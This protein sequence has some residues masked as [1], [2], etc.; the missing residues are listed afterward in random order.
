MERVN[1]N[2][3]IP[4]SMYYIELDNDS[5]KYAYKAKHYGKFIEYTYNNMY[6]Y[7]ENIEEIKSKNSFFEEKG[8]KLV[9]GVYWKFFKMKKY[10]IERRIINSLIQ[11]ITGDENFIYLKD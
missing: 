4:N 2:E 5:L 10:I 11:Q 3:L 7:F 9:G 1:G 8:H 6:A